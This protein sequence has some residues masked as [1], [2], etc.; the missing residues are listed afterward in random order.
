MDS[1]PTYEATSAIHY[2]RVHQ[3]RQLEASQ[4]SSSLEAGVP[5]ATCPDLDLRRELLRLTKFVGLC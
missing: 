3:W 4:D 2:R 1:Y 5:R